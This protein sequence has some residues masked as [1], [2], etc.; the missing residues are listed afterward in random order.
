[1]EIVRVETR[2]FASYLRRFNAYDRCEKQNIIAN[3]ES[4][5]CLNCD[6]YDFYDY[7][8]GTLDGT[9]REKTMRP[10]IGEKKDKK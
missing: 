4:A 1:M 8:D 10:R 5:S 2:C 9:C 3:I 7:Y 6:F